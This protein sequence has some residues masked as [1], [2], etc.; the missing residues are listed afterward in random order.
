MTTP[1]PRLLHLDRLGLES[2]PFP[3]APDAANYF[4]SRAM[5]Q[6]LAEILHCIDARKGFLLVSGDVGIGKTTLSRRLMR[7]LETRNVHTALVLNTFLQGE[8]L[9]AAIN[10]DFGIADT[11][12]MEQRLAALNEFLLN[13]FRHRR[14]CVIM[15]D[16]A[17][18]LSLESLELVRQISN[19]ETEQE[20]LV[21]IV[22]I[23]QPE[24]LDTLSRPDIRQLTSR[25]ALNIQMPCLSRAELRRYVQFRLNRA[26][27]S[28]D[29][30]MTPA[31]LMVLYAETRGVP[32]RVNLIM[33]RCLYAAAAYNQRLLDARLLRKAALKLHPP[34]PIQRPERMRGLVIATALVVILLATAWQFGALSTDFGQ[35][36]RAALATL[37]APQ[38]A[39]PRNDK[40]PQSVVPHQRRETPGHKPQLAETQRFLAN[41]AL[42]GRAKV[43]LD[44]LDSESWRTLILNPG[45]WRVR[46]REGNSWPV[47]RAVYRFQQPNGKLKWVTLW[48]PRVE[49]PHFYFHLNTP[50]VA[51]LQGMLSELG[52][53]QASIDGVVGARTV[54][55]IARFQSR[56]GLLPTGTP[57]ADTIYALQQKL[58]VQL[59]NGNVPV[60]VAVEL[61]DQARLPAA[62]TTLLATGAK[63]GDRR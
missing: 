36:S 1:A 44:A 58:E 31:A 37:V 54:A 57:D 27:A 59:D 56:S 47:N 28:S 14:N 53:Y 8:S 29:I 2:N 60:G 46:V 23:A 5:E 62:Q 63:H 20:K 12:G 7:D 26:G 24:I 21:Q 4:T 35:R 49:F 43:F 16:D 42:A 38:A 10:R 61:T 51:T 55:A 52:L 41:F 3:L 18:N 13:H 33:D 50:A 17:Q 30:R 40:A 25:V 39:I 9:I 48:R 22:L 34:R 6:H 11:P 19:L 32:R 15:I 45:G